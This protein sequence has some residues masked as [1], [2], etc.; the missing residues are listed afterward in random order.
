MKPF[1][2]LTTFA[3]FASAAITTGPD[4]G[5]IAPDF[6]LSNQLNQPTSLKSSLGPQGALL[7]FFRS[8]DW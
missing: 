8:A 1:L 2:L 6:T 7:V 4:A 5:A 3:W